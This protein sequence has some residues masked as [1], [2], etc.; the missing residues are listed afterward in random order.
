MGPERTPEGCQ[1][2]RRATRKTI[3]L[4]GGAK[5][6]WMRNANELH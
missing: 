5:I 6:R 4:Q 2:R 1:I 3:A